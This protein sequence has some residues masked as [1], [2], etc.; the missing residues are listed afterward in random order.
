MCIIMD[1]RLKIQGHLGFLITDIC[2]EYVNGI[3]VLFL[4]SMP[5]S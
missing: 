2:Q 4:R 5:N 1:V 3:H